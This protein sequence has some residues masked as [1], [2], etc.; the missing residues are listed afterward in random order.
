MTPFR[1]DNKQFIITNILMSKLFCSEPLKKASRI[2]GSR[3][4]IAF[5]QALVTYHKI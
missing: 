4:E 2:L 1:E 3:N 5:R